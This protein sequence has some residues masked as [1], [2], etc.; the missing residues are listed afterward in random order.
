MEVVVE[1][2]LEIVGEI[3]L[4]GVFEGAGWMLQRRWG[5]LLFGLTLGA[6]GGLLWSVAV[7]DA[8]P[9]V[10]TVVVAAQLLSIPLLA[11][12]GRFGNRLNRSLLIDLAVI[13]VTVVG[14]RYLGWAIAS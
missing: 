13:G 1:L 4:E 5:R 14:G 2:L 8:L 11:G 3:L 7:T 6:L 10:A 12:K 9:L